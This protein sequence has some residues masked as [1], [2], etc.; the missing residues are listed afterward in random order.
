MVRIVN[1]PNRIY[2]KYKGEGCPWLVKAREVIFGNTMRVTEYSDN[3]TCNRLVNNLE[4]RVKWI[5]RKFE[6][7]IRSCPTIDIDT[8][9]TLLQMDY[10]VIIKR[11]AL[12]IVLARVKQKIK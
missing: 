1:D 7:L 5:V 8:L 12:Y 4:A 2:Y 6:Y 11:I 9:T 3:H 10:K